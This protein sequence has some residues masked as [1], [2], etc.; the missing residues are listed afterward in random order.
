[1]LGL[2]GLKPGAAAYCAS[3]GACVLLTKRIA[4]EYAG[5]R[6][7]CN[8]YVDFH[9][10]LSYFGRGWGVGQNQVEEKGERE[11][12]EKKKTSFGMITDHRHWA[13]V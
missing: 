5:E 12:E 6:I 8:W 11:K 2:V 10:D 13:S 9:L 1:M 7:H 4:V 3:K